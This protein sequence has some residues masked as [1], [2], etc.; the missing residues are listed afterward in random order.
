MIGHLLRSKTTIGFTLTLAVALLTFSHSF[1]QTFNYSQGNLDVDVTV[2]NPCDGL[3]NGFITFTVNSA[4]GGSANLLIIDGPTD[5]FIATNIPVGSSFIFN[6]SPLS[7]TPALPAGEYDFIIVDANGTDVINTFPNPPP[8]PVELESLSPI[9]INLQSQINNTSCLTPNGEIQIQATGGSRIPAL[10]PTPGSFTITWTSDNGYGGLPAVDMDW[11]GVNPVLLTGLPG[12]TY[13]ALIEDNYSICSA[14]FDIVITEPTPTITLVSDNVELCQGETAVDLAYSATTNTPDEYS[15]DFDATAEGEGFVDVAATA[16]PASP[17]AITVPGGGA[18]GIYNAVLRVTNTTT[19]CFSDTPI[20]ITIQPNPTITLVDADVEV[21]SGE[22]SVDL[23]YSATTGTPDQYSIDFDATAEGEGFVDVAATALPASPIAITVPGGGAPGT[24]N[25]VLRVTNTTTGCF[26]D[27]PITITIQPN[28]TITLVDADVEVCSGETSVGLA[29][30]ATTASPDEYSI[31]FDATAEGEGFADVVNSVLPAS[32]ITVTVPGGATPG[33]YNAVLTVRNSTTGCVSSTTNITITIHPNP[34]ITLVDADVEV[35]SGETSVDLAY[36]AT[37]GTPD[38]YSIDFDATAEGEGFVDVAATALPASPIAI[39]VP[40]GGT[41]GTYNAV[42]R[43]T[44]TTTGCFSDTPITITIQP[45]PTITLVDADV[46]V[47]SGE[48]SVDLAYSATTGTPDQY[49]IDFDATA[50]GEG[51]VDVA[52][53]ALPASPIA[54]TVPGGGTP[55]TYNAVL[56]V[57]NTTTG[58]FSDTPITITIQPNPTITLVDADVEVCSGETSVGLAYSATTASPDEYSIDFDATAEGEGFADVVNSVLPASPITVTVPGGATPGVYNAV[59]TVR[60]STT[61]CVSSTTNITITIHPNPTITLV[62]ADVEVCSGDTSVDL[63]YSA[64]TGTPDQYS[65]DFDATAE[66]EGFVD[67][68]ATALPASPIAITVPGGGTPGTYNAVLRVTNT[69]TGCFSDTPITITIQPNPTITLVDAD[70]EVC[71]GETSVDLAYSATTGTPDQYSIDFDAT[72]EGEGFVD[73]AATALPASPIAITV[74]GG[75]TPG[76]YNAVLRVTNTTTGCFS[77]TPITITIQPNPT[78]TLVDADVEVC[79]GETS[80]DL[81]YSATTGTPDQYSIDF[82]ATAEG[83]GF[84]DVAAT[85]L[86]ASPIA[87]TVPGGGTPG[88]YNAV[89]RVTNTTTGCFSDTPITITI[90]PNP[91]ITLVDADVE[92]CSGETSVDL[93]YSATTGTPDQYSIDFDATAEGEGFVDVAATA[94]PASPIAITVPGGGTPGTY[95]AV[96]RVTNTTTGCFSDTPI[97]ITIQPNPTITLVDAD[98]EVCSGETSVGLAY[99]AT[100]ASPDEYSI[101]FDATAEGEGFA[102]VVNSVL[103][104]SP[105]TVT[106]PGGATAGVYNGVLTVRNSTTGCVSST[107][108]ITITIHPNPTITLVMQT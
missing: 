21:C 53:T 27:T 65:I 104:A 3:D 59:L 43:V 31:D 74:P 41:P 90:Q 11:N 99:S 34:T 45:N 22:T 73:V 20:T 75:G 47:C 56:R 107:T 82:D 77:D 24:Y 80:V 72:A 10:A 85:A 42:L 39:T 13:T 16:L 92:V 7:G 23:A 84:V 38:Q 8:N 93:A 52:A 67:V 98:V 29:Y 17:I 87:I 91:T 54:I 28:P 14:T 4:N 88:I 2:S 94:L 64:T 89:L 49:S 102:D 44:N 50:E 97:T 57:T 1:G 58:C 51:F 83:E 61:G 78:I 95:N 35:C 46:E 37:T 19:G 103:P 108:N 36:S 81:A 96:L 33:V 6:D 101:D 69:T 32:P 86:P 30:S 55:G 63:A 68:A 66:G 15:I 26:S 105:I 9:G 48:T 5:Y 106:V 62:D 18:P 60:N 25:A 40:G 79:S 12:G 76:T 70:V 100:T 71:S